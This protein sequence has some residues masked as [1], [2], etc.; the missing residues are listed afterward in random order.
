M[1]IV[2]AQGPGLRVAHLKNLSIVGTGDRV[3][4]PAAQRARS[5]IADNAY[6]VGI[7]GFAPA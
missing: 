4:L 1:G 7:V 5:C 3:C 2:S 6:I